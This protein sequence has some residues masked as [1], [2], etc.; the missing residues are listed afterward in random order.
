MVVVHL[1]SLPVRLY[2]SIC[3]MDSPPSN[4]EGRDESLQVE[5]DGT[6][7]TPAPAA[8]PAADAQEDFVA[9]PASQDAA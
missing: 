9:Q 3:I 6:D 1:Y 5:E 8:A 7:G 4:S 2:S